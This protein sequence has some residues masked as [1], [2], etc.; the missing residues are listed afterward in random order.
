MGRLLPPLPQVHS[1]L[2]SCVH[3]TPGLCVHPTP[4]PWVRLTPGPVRCYLDI[5]LNFRVIRRLSS[6][7]TVRT[8]SLL[9]PLPSAGLRP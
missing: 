3:P 1:P 8:E 6:V 4:G 7:G 2:S 9:P 5:S